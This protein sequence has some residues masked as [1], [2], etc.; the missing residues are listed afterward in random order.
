MALEA[1]HA[2]AKQAG[3]GAQGQSSGRL[4]FCMIHTHVSGVCIPSSGEALAAPPQSTMAP[5]YLSGAQVLRFRM[6]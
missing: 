6:H 4:A 1:G 2:G 3:E 5:L